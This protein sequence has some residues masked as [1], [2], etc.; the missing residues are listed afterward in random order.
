MLSVLSFY[1]FYFYLFSYSRKFVICPHYVCI[2][3]FDSIYIYL[4]RIFNRFKKLFKLM[5]NSFCRIHSFIE[6]YYRKAVCGTDYV[7]FEVLHRRSVILLME[8]FGTWYISSL[9]L[10]VRDT[11]PTERTDT[12]LFRPFFFFF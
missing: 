5:S 1:S 9:T 3:M 8:M 11:T 2:Q 10:K 7:F 6:Q 4:L 12:T